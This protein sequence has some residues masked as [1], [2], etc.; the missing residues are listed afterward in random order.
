V[1]IDVAYQPGHWVVQLGILLTVF[2]LLGQFLPSM[3]VNAT[4]EPQGK[5]VGI[6]TLTRTQ[7]FA[8]RWRRR[9]Q[10]TMT[11]ARKDVEVPQ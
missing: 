7:G 2:G 11:D 8:K 3:E 10:S 1:N 9:L 5:S 6:R 4:I